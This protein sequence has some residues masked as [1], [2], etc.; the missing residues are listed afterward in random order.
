MPGLTVCGALA[1]DVHL[2]HGGH[3]LTTAAASGIGLAVIRTARRLGALPTATTRTR[4]KPPASWKPAP[5]VVVVTGEDDLLARRPATPPP[6]PDAA[7]A[8][9]STP[10]PDPAPS[11][12]PP[13]Y[14]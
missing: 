3:V 4:A 2:R 9:F 12:S 7:Y 14:T 5:P 8:P 11:P 13:A 1:E 6:P 10:S